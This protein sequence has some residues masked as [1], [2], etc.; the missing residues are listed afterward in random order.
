MEDDYK[1]SGVVLPSVNGPKDVY[2]SDALERSDNA[3]Q[4]EIK[5]D[6]TGIE[7]VSADSEAAAVEDSLKSSSNALP[8]V[9]LQAEDYGGSIALPHYGYRQPSADYFNSNLMVYNFVQADI[10]GKVN[11]VQ[12]YDERD[13]GKGADALCS[14]RLRFHLAKLKQYQAAGITP[15]LNMTLLDNCVGQNKSQI[16]MKF[17][18]LLSLYFYDTVA[19][20]Y[21]LPGHTHM[22]PDRVVAHCKNAIKGLNLY[23]PGQIAEKCDSVKGINAQWLRTT[24][25]DRPF[26]VGQGVILDKYFKDLPSGYTSFYFFEFTRGFVTF[27]HLATTPDSEARTIQLLDLTSVLKDELLIELFGKTAISDVKMTDLNLPVNPGRLLSETKL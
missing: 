20:M 4:E 16:V 21:F 18:C 3:T 1:H 9:A 15:R 8:L 7:G 19:L 5:G 23:T 26:R 27:R 25:S 2:L 6:I 10:T 13:Q 17:A 14:L 12:F 11:N 22:L 24:D